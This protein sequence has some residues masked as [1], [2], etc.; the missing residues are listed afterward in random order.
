MYIHVP[1]Q[2]INTLSPFRGYTSLYSCGAFFF[3]N[4]IKMVN[5]TTIPLR[6]LN[7]QNHA[8]LKKMSTQIYKTDVLYYRILQNQAKFRK[9]NVFWCQ[10]VCRK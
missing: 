7:T 2:I 10:V 9:F 8:I 5:D 6:Y 3:L 4:K 1:A